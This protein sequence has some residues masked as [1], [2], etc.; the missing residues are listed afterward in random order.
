VPIFYCKDQW[1]AFVFVFGKHSGFVIEKPFSKLVFSR[2]SCPM[3]GCEPI[4][5]LT[6]VYFDFPV[7]VL[8]EHFNWFNFP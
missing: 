5:A 7:A 8:D 3:K 4:R 1:C 6:L 2:L